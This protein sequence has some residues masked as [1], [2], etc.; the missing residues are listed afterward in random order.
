[1]RDQSRFLEIH[2]TLVALATEGLQR[3]GGPTL[4][5][6]TVGDETIHT[7]N[8]GQP[9]IPIAPSW[10]VAENDLLISLTAQP[11]IGLLNSLQDGSLS[12]ATSMVAKA[13]V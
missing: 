9:G 3:A 11:L 8:L 7:L 6:S 5:A 4:D 2:D 12:Q 13:E 10:C 1:L